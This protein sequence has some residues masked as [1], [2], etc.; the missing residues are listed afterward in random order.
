[1]EY[2]LKLDPRCWC[3]ARIGL[4]PDLEHLALLKMDTYEKTLKLACKDLENRKVIHLIKAPMELVYG[5]T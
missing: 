3:S 4:S 1:M 5:V 2:T